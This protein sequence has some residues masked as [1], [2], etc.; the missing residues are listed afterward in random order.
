MNLMSEYKQC[1]TAQEQEKELMNIL[2]DSS[3]YRDMSPE[4]RQKLLNYLVSSYFTINPR[5][6]SRA[7][8]DRV[9]FQ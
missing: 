2:V 1:G 9:Q 4:D 6:S 8:P 7:L 3:L 5:K